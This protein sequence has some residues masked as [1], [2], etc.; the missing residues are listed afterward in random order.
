MTDTD[1]TKLHEVQTLLKSRKTEDR[2]RAVHRMARLPEKAR[3]PLL[4]DALRDKS[5]YVA[6]LAAEALG[7]CADLSAAAIM[8]E[9]FLYFSEDGPKRDP[10]CHIRASLAFAFGRLEYLGATEAL[11]VG[12]RTVQIE[13]V[14][15]VPF[16]TGAHLRANCALAMAQTSTPEALRDISLLLFDI[17]GNALG[18]QD[19]SKAAQVKVEPRKAAAQALARLGDRAGLLPLTIKLTHPGAEVPEVLQECMQAVVDLEDPRAL[20][21]LTP[22]LKHHDPALAA[23]AALMIARTRAPEA[24]RLLYEATENLLGEALR[25]VVLALSA[26][27][28]EEGR[29]LLSLLVKNERTA[30]RLAVV[31]ALADSYDAGDRACLE[32]L[33]K[34]DSQKVRDA[35]QRALNG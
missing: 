7:E 17:S 8:A 28:G 25:A 35:A 20:E 2:I 4:L 11:R 22:Y 19:L 32:A 6:S 10:G 15:G 18:G 33:T 5:N 27:R 21:L 12:I 30:V 9:R 3:M 13:P 29:A 16:D 34:D 23:Y 14:G 1:S 31:E 26:L 24:P